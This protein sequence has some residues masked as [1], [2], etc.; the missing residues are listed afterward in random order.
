[1]IYV[2]KLFNICVP[3]EL[4]PWCSPISEILFLNI[5]IKAILV[6]SAV[7]D[8]A[9]KYSI[10]EVAI[11][12][13]LQSFQASYKLLFAPNYLKEVDFFTKTKDFTVALI[14]FVGL[15]CS[16]LKDTKNLDLIYILLFLPIVTFGWVQFEVFRKEDIIKKIKNKSLK[17]E[18]EYEFGLYVMMTLVRD[19][20]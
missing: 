13:V 2:V 6:V 14:F 7:T 12:F 4:I 5:L 9:G 19:S 3:S 8:Q 11:L 15:I 20:A 1:M 17:M 18:I 16:G 10:Y